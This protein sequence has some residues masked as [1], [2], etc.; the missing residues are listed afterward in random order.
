MATWPVTSFSTWPVW[1]A[2]EDASF[3]TWV[4]AT[5]CQPSWVRC[6]SD[7][8]CMLFDY[9]YSGGLYLQLEKSP[10]EYPGTCFTPP[11]ISCHAPRKRYLQ[12]KSPPEL[13]FASF[14]PPWKKYNH[15]LCPPEYSVAKRKNQ[16]AQIMP[17]LTARF[18]GAWLTK[19]VTDSVTGTQGVLYNID[20]MKYLQTIKIFHIDKGHQIVSGRYIS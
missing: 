17:I 5:S 20:R 1:R 10:P 14:M 6:A 2:K 15:L 8:E 9:I 4:R 19:K 11:G 7:N 3:F 16:S 13:Y 12:N 18:R